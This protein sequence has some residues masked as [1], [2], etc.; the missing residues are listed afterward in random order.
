MDIDG[1]RL[2]CADP[3]PSIA[4]RAT[5]RR[6]GVVP[7]HKRPAREAQAE[8]RMERRGN[9][10]VYAAERPSENLGRWPAN[11]ILE[12]QPECQ[13]EGSRRVKAGP[14]GMG[15]SAS[16]TKSGMGKSEGRPID[17]A[18]FRNADGTET[19]EAWDCAEGCPVAVLDEQSGI[20]QSG[21]VKSGYKKQGQTQPSRGGYEGGLRNDIPLTG[22]GDTGG[23]SRFFKQVGGSRE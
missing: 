17:N 16:A 3:N 18:Q 4:R 6:T 22:F 14:W 11:L 8:G 23:A 2:V 5:A 20:L 1:C 12:H 9:P 21:S 7:I 13:R 19:V 10:E 15:K